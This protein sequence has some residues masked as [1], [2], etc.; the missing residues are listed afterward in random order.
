M[1]QA[2]NIKPPTN[3]LIIEMISG[4]LSLF[5]IINDNTTTQQF[6]DSDIIQGFEAKLSKYHSLKFDKFHRNDFTI[7]HSQCNVRYSIDGFKE[8]NQDK[9]LP[10]IAEIV[11]NLF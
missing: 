11:N 4:K 5:S 2:A 6:K 3:D 8:K 9:V 7:L 1:E 10:E